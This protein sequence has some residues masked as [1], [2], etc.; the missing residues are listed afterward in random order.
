MAGKGSLILVIGFGVIMMYVITNLTSLGSR[1]TEHMSWYNNATASKNLA[2]IGTNQGLAFLRIDGNANVRGELFGGWQEITEGAYSGGRY[3]VTATDIAG[4]LVRLRTESRF[5]MTRFQEIRDTVD[6][7]IRPEGINEFRMFSWIANIP[8]NAQFFYGGDEIWGPIHQNGGIHMGN[9]PQGHEVP[10]FHGK[11][12]ASQNIQPVGGERAKFLGGFA[13]GEDE[14][15]VP[16]DFDV[17]RNAAQGENGRSYDASHGDLHIEL[18]GTDIYI[19]HGG[20]DLAG[21]ANDTLSIND[22]TFNR[23]IYSSENIS[24]KGTLSGDLEIGAGKDIRIVGDVKYATDPAYELDHI[25][26]NNQYE[27]DRYTHIAHGEDLLGL[28]ATED[29][30]IDV[31]NNDVEVHGILLAL[32]ELRAANPQGM[33]G[34]YELN[35]WGSIIMRGRGDMRFQ[36]GQDHKGFIQK[37]RFDVRLEEDDFRP[38]FFPGTVTTSFQVVAWYESI[39]LPPF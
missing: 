19:W 33:N 21:D 4:Q 25:E 1:A 34:L 22:E 39:Q 24:I 23:A 35:T 2:S 31:G 16:Q 3:R 12:T 11:V 29:V 7:I 27:L 6:V 30:V 38:Q 14:I 20:S 28:Y 37:Y 15:S 18:D 9:I 13:T 17:M 36:S 5:P 10:I 26:Y 8:G 32:N